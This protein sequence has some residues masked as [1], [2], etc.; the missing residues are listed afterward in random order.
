MLFRS[1]SV[2]PPSESRVKAPPPPLKPLSHKGFVGSETLVLYGFCG[3]SRVNGCSGANGCSVLFCKVVRSCSACWMCRRQTWATC[4]AL[5]FSAPL[6]VWTMVTVY[7]SALAITNS[8]PP[9]DAMSIPSL[10]R[11]S[12]AGAGFFEASSIH[13]EG[14]TRFVVFLTKFA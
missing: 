12:G 10:I 6:E 9:S 3:F 8:S 14:I 13:V 2:K 5:E 1:V 11:G 4:T 7:P